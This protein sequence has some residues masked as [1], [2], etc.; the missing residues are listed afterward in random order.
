MLVDVKASHSKVFFRVEQSKRQ[1]HVTEADYSYPR[2]ASLNS[3]FE[4]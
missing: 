2:L 1:P 3:G 4:L